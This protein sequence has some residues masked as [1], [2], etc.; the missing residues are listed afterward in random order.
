MISADRLDD[1]GYTSSIQNGAM[2][3]SKGSLIVARAL[4]I[5]TLYLMHART[6]RED[7]NVATDNASE[8]EGDAEACR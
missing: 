3:F 5:N 4:K 6:C 1:E 2:K 8:S 7:V